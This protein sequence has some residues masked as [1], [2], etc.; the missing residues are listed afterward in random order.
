VTDPQPRR[1]AG[2]SLLMY[3]IAGRDYPVHTAPGCATCASPHRFEIE[4]LIATGRPY[5]AIVRELHLEG[6]GPSTQSMSNHFRGDHMPM[7][8]AVARTLL[9]RR[10]EELSRDI[11]AGVEEV[12]DDVLFSRTVLRTAFDGI[13][14]GELNV[15]VD[16]G[17]AAARMLQVAGQADGGPVDKQAYAEAFMVY[18]ETA[19][20]IMSAEQ[21]ARFGNELRTNPILRSL[22]ERHRAASAPQPVESLG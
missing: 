22:M 10:A 2:A 4:Q 13:A 15:S 11:E 21:F 6:S 8:S 18:H 3:R 16:Q 5:S 17:L 9:E 1:E 19:R 20:R 12:V 7:R 14:S